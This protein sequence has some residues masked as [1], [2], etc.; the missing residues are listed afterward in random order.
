[1]WGDDMPEYKINKYV[2]VYKRAIELYTEGSFKEAANFLDLVVKNDESNYNAAYYLGNLYY[3][4]HGVNKDLKRAFDLYMKAATRRVT[5]AEYMVGLCYLKGEGVKQELFQAVAWFTEAAKYAHPLSQYYLGVAYMNG[6]GITKDV[7]RAAQ[8]LV[9]AANQGIVEAQRDAGKC[10]E[11]LGNFHGA[12]TLFLAGAKNGDAESQFRLSGYY[13]EGKGIT[14]STPL[15]VFYLEESA[16]QNYAPAQVALGRRYDMGNGVAKDPRHALELYQTAAKAG[17]PE[18]EN[19]LAESYHSGEGIIHDNTLA[20]QWWTKAAEDGNIDAMIHLAEI[21]TD[22]SDKTVM[23]DLVTA[24]SWWTKA[25]E[26]GD[27]YAMFRLGDCL[28][29]GIGVSNVNLDDAFKWYRLAAQNGYKDAEEA[30]ARF[31]KS[32]TGKVKLKKV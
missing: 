32:F 31:S 16:K 10:Y 7:P 5:E 9:H 18:A 15:A 1:M 22:P 6:E 8:W 2:S 27:A 13:S 25:A 29:N 17:N 20:V 11:I 30:C 28:E 19:A 14:Q 26:A 23:V 12:A 3:N 21:L 24:K 4:G